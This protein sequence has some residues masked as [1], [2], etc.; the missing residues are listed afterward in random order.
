MGVAAEEGGAANHADFSFGVGV[1]VA[2]W[3]GGDLGGDFSVEFAVS[4]IDF[5]NF[6]FQLEIVEVVF[7]AEEFPHGLAGESEAFDL[8]LKVANLVAGAG[9]FAACAV[10]GVFGGADFL[11][12]IVVPVHGDYWELGTANER[13][14]LGGGEFDR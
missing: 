3:A 13:E 1:A 4:Q 6:G 14:F 7:F 9:G 11:L 12:G 10:C 2:G 8:L 5:E